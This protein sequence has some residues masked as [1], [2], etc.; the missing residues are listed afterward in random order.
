M[1]D[2]EKQ[3][4]DRIAR[5]ADGQILYRLLQEELCRVSANPKRGALRHENGRRSLAHDLM[6]LMAEGID[7]SVRNAPFTASK[8]EPAASGRKLTAREWIA[9]QPSWLDPAGQPDAPGDA[10]TA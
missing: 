1:T 9:A 3:A 10:G 2:D 8:R 7:A 4:L 5:T 6:A